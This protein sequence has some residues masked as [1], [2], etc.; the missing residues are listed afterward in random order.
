MRYFIRTC[1]WAPEKVNREVKYIRL[2]NGEIRFV[3]PITTASHANAVAHGEA[4][5]SAGRVTVDRQAETVEM[6]HRDSFSLSIKSA[7]GNE[8]AEAC[9]RWLFELTDEE[10]AALTQLPRDADEVSAEAMDEARELVR[11]K[12][13]PAKRK[14]RAR[15]RK[16]S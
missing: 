15:A 12:R 4:V 10:R 8:D 7:P 9:R 1:L 2:A 14:P 6:G 3:D 16:A 11:A 13:S 5:V